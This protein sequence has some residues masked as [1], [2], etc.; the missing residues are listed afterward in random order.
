MKQ[1]TLKE[2][3]QKIRRE[4]EALKDL[5]AA[6]YQR[7]TLEGKIHWKHGWF[8]SYEHWAVW[9]EGD[10][11]GAAFFGRNGDM[12]KWVRAGSVAYTFTQ[13]CTLITLAPGNSTGGYYQPEYFEGLDEEDMEAGYELV[14]ELYQSQDNKQSV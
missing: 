5:K 12:N 3:S 1:R 13:I 8:L 10:G 7:A 6:I 11:Y 14:L 9:P 2:A 4:F